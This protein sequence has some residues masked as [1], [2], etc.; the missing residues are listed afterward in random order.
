MIAL[1]IGLVTWQW[2]LLA[3]RFPMAPRTVA[4]HAEPIAIAPGAVA[5]LRLA[6]A[7]RLTAPD[8]RFGGLSAL[9]IDRGGL[10]AQNDSAVLYRFPRPGTGPA[11]VAISELPDGPGSAHLKVDRD[12]ESLARDPFGRGWWVG[13]ETNNQLWLYDRDFRKALGRID[14][15]A[16]RWPKNLGI[17]AML[18]E[19]TGL[20]LVPERAHEV[21]H[22]ANRRAVSESLSGVGS[23]ISDVV[24]LPDGE[25]I[26][27]TRDLGLTGVRTALGA[28]VR[29]PSGWRVER[30][31][32]LD[33]G[34]FMNL[35]GLTAEPLA[36]GGTRLWLVTDDNF[37]KP[38]ET[39]LFALDV[40]PGRWG[41]AD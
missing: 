15:G 36:G 8:A 7:W 27:L 39:A 41:G 34:R 5:P 22:V 16:A 13:F 9:A 35:E 1:I 40:A 32:P 28:L 38:M 18:A 21:V 6:G 12:S 19:P 3:D 33:V 25:I 29:G 37:Q 14:L 2:S 23:N 20:T 17:E 4:L 26:V 24:R 10:L 30:R 31:V 11:R